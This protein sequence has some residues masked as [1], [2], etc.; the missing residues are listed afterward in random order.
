MPVSAAERRFI[1]DELG[2]QAQADMARLWDAAARM[3]DVA[4]AQFVIDAFPDLVD[5]FHQT[6]AQLAATWFEQSDPD[7]QYVARVAD[8]LPVVQLKS[9]AEWALGA[10]GVQ[11]LSRLEGTVQRAVFNGARETTMLNVAATK[12]KWARHA[13]ANACEFCRL[14]AI[15]GGVY[16][17]EQTAGAKFHD[18]CH[19]LSVEV[20]RG[21]YTPP[22]YVAQWEQDYQNARDEAGSSDVKKILAAWRQQGAT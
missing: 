8:P 15:R 12:S 7:S 19:C 3:E 17:S 18:H 22:P 1:L 9:S 2:R 14:M 5:P 4:F 10:D 6:A 21:D 16:R 13:S 20:R 11:G